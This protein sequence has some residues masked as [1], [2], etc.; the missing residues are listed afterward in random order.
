MNIE[1]FSNEFDI[2]SGISG[3][4]FDEYEKS[5]FLTKAQEDIVRQ[6]YSGKLGDAFESTEQIRRYLAPLVRTERLSCYYSE[7]GVSNDSLFAPLPDDVWFI[8]YEAAILDSDNP[9]IKGK[10]VAVIPV[11]Q[12][13]YHRIKNNPFRGTNSRKVLRLDVEFNE[14]ELIS[15]YPVDTYIVRYI[16]KPSPIILLPLPDGLTING[17]NE[18][19]ECRLDSDIH[20]IILETAVSL[21]IKSKTS[22]TSK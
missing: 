1:E 10:E 12:D 13:E 5:V 17:K 21:A 16:A 22:S 4:N 18:E 20:K 9:C 6:L 8:T 7:T 15:K 14:V 11:T 3:L 19:S 2:L